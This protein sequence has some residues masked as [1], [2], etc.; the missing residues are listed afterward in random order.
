[1]E[2][3]FKVITFLVSSIGIYF[4]SGL[5]TNLI[6][7]SSDVIQVLL[8]NNNVSL[9]LMSGLLILILIELIKLNKK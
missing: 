4:L 3:L 9:T 8:T 6:A 7:P 5:L 1:M 2:N